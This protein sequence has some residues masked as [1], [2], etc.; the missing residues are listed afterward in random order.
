MMSPFDHL[1]GECIVTTNKERNAQILPNAYEG[2]L[3]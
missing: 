3:A 1:T 2:I